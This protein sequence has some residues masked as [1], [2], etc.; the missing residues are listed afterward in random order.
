MAVAPQPHPY[1]LFESKVDTGDVER[2]NSVSQ[3]LDAHNSRT[4]VHVS[5]HL[6]AAQLRLL[7]R[8]YPSYRVV[9]R[10]PLHASQHPILNTT[11]LLDE[12]S[13]WD[14]AQRIFNPRT[15]LDVGGNPRRAFRAGVQVHCA[16]PILDQADIVRNVSRP[17]PVGVTVCTHLAQDC[18]CVDPDIAVATHSLYYLAPEQVY[19]ICRRTRRQTLIATVHNVFAGCGQLLRDGWFYN[20][21]ESVE[22]FANNA[23]Y[24]YKHPSI[25]W[26]RSGGAHIDGH[27]LGWTFIFG[28]EASVVVQFAVRPGT[29][30]LSCVPHVPLPVASHTADLVQ[31]GV[32]TLM[33]LGHDYIG[34]TLGGRRYAVPSAA[35]HRLRAWAGLRPRTNDL[36]SQLSGEARR[37]LKDTDLPEPILAESVAPLVALTVIDLKSGVDALTTIQSHARAISAYNDL[38]KNA[39]I[40]KFPWLSLLVAGLAG[41]AACFAPRVLRRPAAA[42]CSVAFAHALYDTGN[43]GWALSNV[44]SAL[45]RGWRTPVRPVFRLARDFEEQYESQ[46][47]APTE[48]RV[49]ELIGIPRLPTF[50]PVSGE[51]ELEALPIDRD[52]QLIIRERAP[53]PKPERPITVYGIVNTMSVMPACY[54][55]SH[56]SYLAMIKRRMLLPRFRT[57]P[58]F[59][60]TLMNVWHF[61]HRENSAVIFGPH[62][63]GEPARP[64]DWIS[65]YNANMQR[66]LHL[67]LW[68][69]QFGLPANAFARGIFMKRELYTKITASGWTGN[70]PRGIQTTKAAHHLAVVHKVMGFQNHMKRWLHPN[71]DKPW[72]VPCGASPEEMGRYHSHEAHSNHTYEEGDDSNFDVHNCGEEGVSNPQEMVYETMEDVVSGPN[73]MDVQWMAGPTTGF[74]KAWYAMITRYWPVHSG[75]LD[76]YSANTASNISR[77]TFTIALWH[78]RD[79]CI[80]CEQ[81]NTP[82]PH[83]IECA[84]AFD[85]W[86]AHERP[87]ARDL[88]PFRSAQPVILQELVHEQARERVTPKLLDAMRAMAAS[89]ARGMFSGDDSLLRGENLPDSSFWRR[90]SANLGFDYKPKSH[91]GPYAKY[92]ASFCSGLFWPTT[93]GTI[94]GPKPGRWVARQGWFIDLPR[95][96]ERFLRQVARAESLGRLPQCRFVPFLRTYWRRMTRLTDGVVP[97]KWENRKYADW[98]PTSTPAEATDETWLMM[99]ELYGLTREHESQYEKL[100]DSIKSLPAELNFAPFRQMLDLEAIEDEN[101]EPLF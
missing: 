75:N 85:I 25:N 4:V 19:R 42:I 76:T 82:F 34:T 80:F 30:P 77:K 31:L 64:L 40:P 61:W 39:F 66:Q 53:L 88:V 81:P 14:Y 41:L 87:L 90:I 94:L 45:M 23:C 99:Q 83:C 15:V 37:A 44:R 27:T 33:Q 24:S 93:A 13:T 67:E 73:I 59:S 70:R 18:E 65:K 46:R 56:A 95:Q 89:D 21:G 1:A 38:L 52:A 71:L 20:D 92:R 96:D 50:P 28:N 60:Q 51:A 98:V 74:V 11:R 63:A 91:S 78:H 62:H 17:V 6:S 97:V 32:T 2:F 7:E 49:R 69:L 43:L 36:V 100:L 54:D 29:Y 68:F 8:L 101:E 12:E 10:P 72:C 3:H 79:S 16:C 35:Y 55:R 57:M 48:T 26:L 86:W 84:R 22:F 5:Y 58:L 9:F 47:V